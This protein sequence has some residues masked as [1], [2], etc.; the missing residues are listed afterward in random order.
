MAVLADDPEARAS[1]QHEYAVGDDRRLITVFRLG[2]APD[3][4]FP[5]KPRLPVDALIV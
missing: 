1:L 3:R 4:A 5:S 2:V